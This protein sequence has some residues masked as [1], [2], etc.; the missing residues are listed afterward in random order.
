[1]SAR[2]QVLEKVTKA[3]IVILT[4]KLQDFEKLTKRNN[5][6]IQKKTEEFKGEPTT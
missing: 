1:M 3:N 2:I 4:D 5:R 6:D